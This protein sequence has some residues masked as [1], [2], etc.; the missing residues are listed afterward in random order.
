ML[1]LHG[2]ITYLICCFLLQMTSG[3]HLLISFGK[4]GFLEKSKKFFRLSTLISENARIR[5][6][7]VPSPVVHLIAQKNSTLNLLFFD[8]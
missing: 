8:S 3:A 2:F 1:G 7:Q 6:I 4:H 5:T